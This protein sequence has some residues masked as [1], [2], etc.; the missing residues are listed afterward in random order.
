[1]DLRGDVAGSRGAVRARAPGHV[2]RGHLAVVELDDGVARRHPAGPL[3][4]DAVLERAGEVAPEAEELVLLALAP[5]EARVEVEVRRQR[6]RAAAD[7]RD[8]DEA[9]QAVAAVL[10][11]EDAALVV[12]VQVRRVA[13]R[14]PPHDL[15][16]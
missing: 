8:A 3:G 16:V 12:G 7:G 9:R 4:A 14:R 15:R 10:F 2:D 1:M 13:P 6:G 11:V 5:R